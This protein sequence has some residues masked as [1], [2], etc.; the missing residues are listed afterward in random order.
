MPVRYDKET[1]TLHIDLAPKQRN[2]LEYATGS[3]SAFI[4]DSDALTK[5][6]IREARNFIARALSAGVEVDN[7]SPRTTIQPTPVWEDADSSMISAFKYDETAGT[8]DVAFKRTGVYR[9]F[10]VP[11]QAVEGLRKASSK[12]S[13]MRAMIIDVYPYEKVRQ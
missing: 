10:N 13:Y 9:Y 7:G 3:F 2:S 1:D 11:F 8:L 6:T 4:D 5:I 12:G